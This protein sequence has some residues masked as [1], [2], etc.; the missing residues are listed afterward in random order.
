[1]NE[2]TITTSVMSA[3]E[4]RL[5]GSVVLKHAD[6]VTGDIP[7]V[8]IS[9]FGGTS[10]IELKYLRKGE[11]LKDIVKEG[12]MILGHQLATTCN[13]RAWIVVFE[14][15]PRAVSVWRPG[16]LF[17]YLNPTFNVTDHDGWKTTSKEPVELG[18]QYDRLNLIAVLRD[19]GAFRVA[20]WD[21][22]LPSTLV[23]QAL[24]P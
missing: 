14:A 13:G 4:K 5:R 9:V 11:K 3:S 19:H 24:K 22:A 17:R 12:Q 2:G 10:W 20:G 18:S 1:M 16:V 8:S 15:F 6:K 7:D 21:Y 23:I